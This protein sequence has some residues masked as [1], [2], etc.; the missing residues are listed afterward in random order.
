MKKSIVSSLCLA[1]LAGAALLLSA[2][3]PEDEPVPPPSASTSSG[4]KPAETPTPTPAPTLDP[5]A[6]AEEN[7]PFFLS[8]IEGVWESDTRGEIRAYVDAVAKAGFDREKMQATADHSTIGRPAE[9]MQLSVLWKDECLIGQFGPDTGA[10][11]ARIM[12]PLEGDVCLL[13]DTEP[14]SG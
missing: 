12:A 3:A 1:T 5:G 9:T 2:C 8:V 14:I 11:L 10:P 7:L 4:P 6:S 13:G